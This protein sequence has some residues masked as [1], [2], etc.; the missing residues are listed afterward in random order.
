MEIKILCETTEYDSYPN[1]KNVTT[2]FEIKEKCL[3]I[4]LFDKNEQ[5]LD[6]TE[7]TIEDARKL[8]KIIL[9]Y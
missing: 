6:Q 4:Y 8:A 3:V 9:N 7:I 1:D 5:I 2:G